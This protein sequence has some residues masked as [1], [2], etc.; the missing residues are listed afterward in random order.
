MNG[1]DGANPMIAVPEAASSS[2]S[3]MTHASERRSERCPKSGWTTE[4]E[5]FIASTS[6]AAD[7]SV[8]P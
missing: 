4:D 3:G 6:V 5:R 7:A 1:I 2:A 8:K